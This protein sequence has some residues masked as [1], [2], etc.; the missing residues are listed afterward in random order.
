M[1]GRPAMLAVAL[2][3]GVALYGL[4]LALDT[5]AW[6]ATDPRWLFPLYAIFTVVPL[7]LHLDLAHL[8]DPLFL[9][10][11]AGFAALLAAVGAYAG[12]T[13][14]PLPGWRD[15]GIAF[16]FGLSV[17]ALWWILTPFLQAS[18]RGGRPRGTPPYAEL[19]EAGWQNT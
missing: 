15:S 12:S 3:Q 17:A 7:V 10:G 4:H 14:V 18:V 5:E 1:R 19:F 13:I 11:V 6:P 2:L 16:A 8:R 9:R